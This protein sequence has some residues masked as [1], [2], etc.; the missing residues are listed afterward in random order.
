M[1]RTVLVVMDVLDEHKDLLDGLSSELSIRYIKASEVS[2][3][4]VE[5]VEII[6]G[7]ISPNL[8][9]NCKNLKLL[10][11]NSA[12][13]DGYTA[14]GILPDGV[15]LANATGAYGLAISEHMLGML[16][17]LM[18]K[19]DL[20]KLNQG[21]HQWKDEGPVTSIYG[22]KT[23][24]VGFG[25]IGNEFGVRMHALGSEVTA[26]RNN[27]ANKPDYINS[28]HKIDDLYANLS[29]ADIV[30]ACLPG[31][32]QTNKLFDKKAFDQMK[33]GSYFINVGR[34]TAVDTDALCDALESG[35]LAGAALDVTD[36]EPLPK[37]NRL[38][39]MSNVLI[40][41]HVSGGYHLKE[42]HNRIIGIAAKNI[43]HLLNREPFENIVDMK[44]GY[45]KNN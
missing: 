32:P 25:D 27:I 31:T 36:P 11:L 17:C 45:R 6:V 8:L 41:P 23:L 34:G 38:W 18:K 42:T 7:N 22:S 40:T 20:Y 33:E 3:Q 37:D 15:C 21:S 39:N 35:K 5:D 30:A 10:Q 13:T 12:G 29:K 19:L 26:I 44:T 14:P 9:S 24:I 16:L 43:K 4:D 28:I 2:P 1:K